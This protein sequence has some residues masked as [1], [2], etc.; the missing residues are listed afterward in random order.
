MKKV[1]LLIAAIVAIITLQS[2][3][4]K[5]RLAEQI[6]GSWASSPEKLNTQGDISS[7]SM[8]EIFEFQID[9]DQKSSGTLNLSGLVSISS[10]LGPSSTVNQ[11]ISMSASGIISASGSWS[12]TDDDE[13]MVYIDA[14]TINATVDSSAVVLSYNILSNEDRPDLTTLKPAVAEQVKQQIVLLA[15]QKISSITKID[16][17]RIKDKMMSCEIGKSNLTFRRQVAQ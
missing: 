2:C 6:E 11:P 13:I 7:A 5:A 4:E 17:I 14:R 16:D 12:A 8:I 9:P 10:P 3:D 1:S 15:G